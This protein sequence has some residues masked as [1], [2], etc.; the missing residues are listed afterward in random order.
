LIAPRRAAA[1]CV[2][3]F[4]A[5]VGPALADEV[6]VELT[7]AGL[8]G[9]FYLRYP[10]GALDTPV[11]FQL[12]RGVHPVVSVVVNGDVRLNLLVDSGA[13]VL[14]LNS[15]V[16]S[17]FI[18]DLCFSNG[19]CFEWLIAAM[20]QS[21]YT[22]SRDTPGAI[23]GLIGYNLLAAL[24]VSIDYEKRQL[25]FGR[26]PGAGAAR[27]A[28]ETRPDDVRPFGRAETGGH[29]IERILFDTGSS[30]VRL[31]ADTLAALG[32]AAVP[33]GGEIAFSMQKDEIS[34][35]FEITRMCLA[36]DA[37]VTGELA[38]L[39]AWQA[40]GGS[41]WR[42][43]RVTIDAED[44]A[45]VLERYETPPNF[46]NAREKWGLQLD[47]T[48]AAKIVQVDPG[49]PAARAGIAVADR[50]VA[51]DGKAILDIGYLGAHALLEAEGV[52]LVALD[53]G[54]AGGTRNVVLIAD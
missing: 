20:P 32:D 10:E 28:V 34:R 5:L 19:L 54:R 24:P 35:L 40:I 15:D 26:E 13:T 16:G 44:S 41:F 14:N 50:L 52:D 33:A 12:V 9:P 38:Q 6:R 51:I 17:P 43:F 23:N 27:I 25:V 48:D 45:F 46:I 36:A 29:D 2:A 39:G 37:C 53:L 42:H 21:R 4:V 8:A 22:A 49:S 7:P 18:K 3:A 47:L 31:D 11:P 30:F 1:A